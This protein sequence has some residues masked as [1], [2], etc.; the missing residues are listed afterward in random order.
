[1]RWVCLVLHQFELFVQKS[2]KPSQTQPPILS[3]KPLSVTMCGSHP[4]G[5]SCS[6]VPTLPLYPLPPNPNPSSY[7]A[8]V[9]LPHAPVLLHPFP[10]PA[11]CSHSPLLLLPRCCPPCPLPMPP[12]RLRPPPLEPSPDHAVTPP[13]VP[14]PRP[15]PPPLASAP[16]ASFSPDASSLLLPQCQRLLPPIA[17]VAAL[18]P[19]PSRHC[20]PPRASIFYFIF[21]YCKLFFLVTIIYYNNSLL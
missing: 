21:F 17:P 7:S 16:L 11:P 12:R 15:H 13:L 3:L 2:Q 19:K 10:R 6:P 14:P 1:M 20:S 9:L 18:G 4:R 8:P 5:A